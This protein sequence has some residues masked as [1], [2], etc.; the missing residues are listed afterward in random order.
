MT[1]ITMER[2]DLIWQELCFAIFSDKNSE[3]L[4]QKCRKV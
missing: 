2:K 3:K 4:S 1:E